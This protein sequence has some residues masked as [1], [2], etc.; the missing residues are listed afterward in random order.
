MIKTADIYDIQGHTIFCDDIRHE[1]G[2]KLT[3]VGIYTG[4]MYTTAEFPIN[5]GKFCFH[6][7]FY[8]RNAIF[9]PNLSIKIFLPGHPYDAPSIDAELQPGAESQQSDDSSDYRMIGANLVFSP[10]T[11][12]AEGQIRVRVLRQGILH[13]IGS[14]NVIKKP[15][16]STASQPPS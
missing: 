8:Q 4:L 3:L 16:P 1:V 5:L 11:I 6:I 9:D 13:R 2:G 7:R 12:N 10:F 14:L 15:T